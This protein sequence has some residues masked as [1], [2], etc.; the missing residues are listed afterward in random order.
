[1]ANR[2]DF[3]QQ[4]TETGNKVVPSLRLLTIKLFEWLIPNLESGAANLNGQSEIKSN[5]W[6][7]GRSLTANTLTY[8][9]TGSRNLKS[10]LNPTAVELEQPLLPEPVRTEL[11]IAW[12]FWQQQF[13][14]R[15]V[16][17]ITWA[18][19]WL[20]PRVAGAWQKV[21]SVPQ[22]SN[23]IT[24]IQQ[25]HNWQKFNTAIAPV[26]RFLRDTS[27][28]KSLHPLLEKKAAAWAIGITLSLF[29]LLK[30]SHSSAVVATKPAAKPLLQVQA[31][32]NSGRNFDD[33]LPP[34]Q[35]DTS[36]SPEQIMVTD[37]QSQVVAATNRYGEALIQSVQTNF[38]LG[39]LI[40]QLTD[41]WY[42]L[43]PNRQ[44]QLLDDLLDRSQT[45][46]FKKLVVAD[47]EKHLIA[48]SPVV[49]SEMVILRR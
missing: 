36:I 2:K 27:L 15:A 7:K 22:V 47:S 6:S 3:K 25:N 29:F 17:G 45:L 44:E 39:R 49:G 43:T 21:Y 30:P 38:K 23:T 24:K 10:K 40:I 34:E 26:G 31:Q 5:I 14:P 28:P 4:L 19:D 46:K 9:A 1:M 8:M 18:V 35:G 20:D 48:R 33:F 13:V 12:D 32:R 11:K 37:I 16:S 42:Q 41:A